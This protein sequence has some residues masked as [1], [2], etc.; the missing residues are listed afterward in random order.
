MNRALV[1]VASVL[2]LASAC[3]D[4]TFTFEIPN[5]YVGWVTVQYRKAG[6]GDRKSATRTTI[7][8]T[9]DGTACTAVG[10]FPKTT[11]FSEFYYV[12]GDR[13]V[14]E[15]KPTGWGEGGMI[16]AESTEID[17][18]QYRFFVGSEQQLNNA[19][20]SRSRGR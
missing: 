13:R 17:G 12:A 10:A 7:K 5:G 2:L 9:A 8:V 1:I 15:L 11:W 20:G 3:S 6:C 19:G 18:H 16:W 4:R 14:K